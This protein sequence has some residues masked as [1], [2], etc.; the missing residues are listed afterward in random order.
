MSKTTTPPKNSAL[1]KAVRWAGSPAELAIECRVSP[2][3]VRRWIRIGQV[4]GSAARLLAVLMEERHE[5]AFEKR[6]RGDR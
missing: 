4:P 1:E 3:A 6:L 5:L 2:D